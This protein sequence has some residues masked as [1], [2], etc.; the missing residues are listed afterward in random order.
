MPEPEKGKEYDPK[1]TKK[2]KLDYREDLK[3]RRE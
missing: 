2:Y 1:N 3:L